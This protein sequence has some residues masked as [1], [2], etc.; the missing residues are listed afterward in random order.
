MDTIRSLDLQ[1]HLH[2]DTLRL[3][4]DVGNYQIGTLTAI[5]SQEETSGP[6]DLGYT[7][8]ELRDHARLF[9]A[10]VGELQRGSLTFASPEYQ[11]ASRSL[12][13][14]AHE[15]ATVLLDDDYDDDLS[16]SLDGPAVSEDLR[17]LQT[18]WAA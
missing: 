12:L 5:A 16:E 7:P 14:A 8:Q 11:H 13:R 6:S 18:L 15:A 4:A 1:L 3:L 2:P 17:C 9:E 10:V